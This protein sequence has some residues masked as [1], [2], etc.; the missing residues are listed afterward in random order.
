MTV[1][2][3]QLVMDTEKRVFSF[4]QAAPFEVAGVEWAG[5]VTDLTGVLRPAK[6][7][8]KELVIYLPDAA[9]GKLEIQRFAIV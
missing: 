9:S 3:F 1:I 7:E 2:N 4:A 6:I 5:Y 8:G